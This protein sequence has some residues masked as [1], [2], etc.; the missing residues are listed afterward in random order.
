MQVLDLGRGRNIFPESLLRGWEQPRTDNEGV[1][2]LITSE[3]Q[4]RAAT[5]IPFTSRQRS[6]MGRA[7]RVPARPAAGNP[8]VQRRGPIQGQE[9][10][11]RPGVHASPGRLHFSRCGRAG[12]LAYTMSIASPKL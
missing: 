7:V 10:R 9:R 2:T 1:G 11:I 12:P 6:L 3:R 8:H 5:P 4:E